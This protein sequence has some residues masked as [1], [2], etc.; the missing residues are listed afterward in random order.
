M[1]LSSSSTAVPLWPPFPL[2]YYT[3][4]RK[5][6]RTGLCIVLHIFGQHPITTW[7][8]SDGMAWTPTWSL[9][10][11]FSNTQG[12]ETVGQGPSPQSEMW[13]SLANLPTSP[14]GPHL[15]P[16]SVNTA[17][18]E[19][20]GLTGTPGTYSP[21]KDLALGT[22]PVPEWCARNAQVPFVRSG[23]RH[24]NKRNLVWKIS[25]SYSRTCL[26]S[27]YGIG[28]FPFHNFQPIDI[29]RAEHRSSTFCTF[30]SAS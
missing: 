8:P 7:H 6:V 26:M 25:D 9:F 5:A 15:Q 17:L 24:S 22:I 12:C 14:T 29:D 3:S 11:T 20:D 13:C 2:Y 10:L 19:W 4:I 28:R 23:G 1:Q 30:L 21:L 27:V 18:V 16:S